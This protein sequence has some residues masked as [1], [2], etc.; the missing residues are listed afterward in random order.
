MV[1][2]KPTAV[3]KTRKQSPK[4]ALAMKKPRLYSR[5]VIISYRRN[6]VNLHCNSMLVRIEGVNTRKDT[7][8]YMGKKIEYHYKCHGPKTGSKVRSVCG[9]I[10]APHGSSGVVRAKFETNLTGQ[11]LGQPAKVYM[12]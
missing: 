3:V 8:Y 10:I 12:Y 1:E 9:K 7:Q 5:A 6:R 2:S 4:K 11:S